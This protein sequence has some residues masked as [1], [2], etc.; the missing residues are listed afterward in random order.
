MILSP[1]ALFVYNRPEHTQK[2]IESLARNRL[3]DET[4]LHVFSDGPKTGEDSVDVDAVR[5]YLKTV[6]GFKALHLHMEQGNLGCASSIIKGVT[7]VIGEYGRIIVLEDDLVTS[8][9]YL[10]YM[11]QSL[12]RYQAVERV[13]H[14]C[15]SM[16]PIDPR[17]LPETFFLRHVNSCGWGTWER[18]WGMLETSLDKLAVCFDDEKR[19]YLN[20][21]GTYDF[22]SHLEMN[23]AGELN[24]WAIRWYASVVLHGGLGLYPSIPLI[25]N[26]GFD[27]S[28]SHCG[29]TSKFGVELRQGPIEDFS[30][31]VQENPVALERVKRFLLQSE[32]FGVRARR[33]LR[34]LGGP[35]LP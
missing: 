25:K 3:A 17:G 9:W 35:F 4:I 8:P 27:G 26:I 18:A 31:I 22:W 33:F 29:K 20:L 1:V 32:P 6:S 15:G 34:S 24:T 30:E 14:V 13:M 7:D 10:L 11:N 2:T 16:Y 19:R 12:D 5:T 23:I 28:G 21:D